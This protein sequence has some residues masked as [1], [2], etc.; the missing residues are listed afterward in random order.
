MLVIFYIFFIYINHIKKQI[1]D[2][3][4]IETKFLVK[5]NPVAVLHKSVLQQ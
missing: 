1:K 5:Y 4:I 3:N 2:M